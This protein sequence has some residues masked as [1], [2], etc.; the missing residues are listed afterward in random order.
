[1]SYKAELQAN[2]ADLLSILNA[3]DALP[4]AVNIDSELATQ[5]ALIEQIQD[6]LSNT[7]KGD[8][9][10]AYT[11]GESHQLSQLVIFSEGDTWQ[12][13]IDS[14]YNTMAYYADE[15]FPLLTIRTPGRAESGPV[16]WMVLTL[17]GTLATEIKLTDTIIEGYVYQFYWDD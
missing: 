17:D 8:M 15:I 1:M 14:K 7:A 13:F 2:N 9:K 6:A 3:V 11:Y 4:D 10:I 5:D 16:P 12:D